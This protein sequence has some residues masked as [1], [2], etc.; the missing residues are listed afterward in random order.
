M[1]QQ[2]I[3][4]LANQILAAKQKDPSADISALEKQ[5]DEMVYSLYGL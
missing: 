3:I 4:A 5:I 1:N 2:P